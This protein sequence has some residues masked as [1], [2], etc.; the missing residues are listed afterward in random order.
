MTSS[1]RASSRRCCATTATRCS[2]C[3][4]PRSTWAALRTCGC[5]RCTA[6]TPRCPRTS[7]S[8]PI[9]SAAGS[10]SVSRSRATATPTSPSSSAD[11]S[12]PQQGG[13]MSAQTGI[14]ELDDAALVAA[15]PAPSPDLVHHVRVS[16]QG[17]YDGRRQLAGY[18][19]AFGVPSTAGGSGSSAGEP[20]EQT[21]TAA[22]AAAL[23]TFG[24]EG[25]AGGKPLYVRPPPPVPTRLVPIPPPPAGPPPPL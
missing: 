23:R 9:S 16:R 20:V 12:P 13:T 5:T 10:T 18:R 21:G 11:L 7:R 4:R 2:T 6:R 25:P 19:A 8:W 22:V 17:I 1:T 15:R 24:A 14:H 3:S